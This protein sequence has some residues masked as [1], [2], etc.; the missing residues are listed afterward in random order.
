MSA[1]GTPVTLSTIFGSRG[2]ARD[3]FE[4]EALEEEGQ[5]AVEAR[6]GKAGVVGADHAKAHDCISLID[7]QSGIAALA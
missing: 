6:Y 1:P 7:F 2:C 4:L 5:R 3:Q